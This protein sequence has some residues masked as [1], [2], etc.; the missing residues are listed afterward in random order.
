MLTK[1]SDNYSLDKCIKV[2]QYKSTFNRI[3]VATNTDQLRGIIGECIMC[4][5]RKIPI[6]NDYR[7]LFFMDKL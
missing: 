3:C 2:L 5:Y 7:V 4:T 1:Q 6:I